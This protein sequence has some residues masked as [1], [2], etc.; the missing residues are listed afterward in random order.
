MQSASYILEEHDRWGMPLVVSLGLHGAL[1]LIIIVAT[2]ARGM[3]GQVWGTMGAGGGAMS[4]TIVRSIPLPAQ[5]QTENT[6]VLANDNKGL[7]QSQPKAQEQ[8]QDNNAI[9]IARNGREKEKPADRNSTNRR[10][11]QQQQ[12]ANQIPYGRGGPANALQ[13]S[14]G[15][16]TGGL[17]VE[18]TGDFAGRY[19]WYVEQ[20]RN[21]IAQ[22][23]SFYQVDP[24]VPKGARVT[25]SFEILRNGQPINIGMKEPSAFPSLNDSAAATLKRIDTF[26]PLPGDY[27]G[28]SVR[29]DFYFER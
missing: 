2:I 14:M 9:E 22:N 8:P 21:K 4:A 16:G 20:V 12:A 28:N 17:N 3:P 19:G 7:S 18:G 11:D 26:G 6:N 5:P 29:V 1:L 24:N 10:P 27:R 25:V 23:W 15:A 13:F